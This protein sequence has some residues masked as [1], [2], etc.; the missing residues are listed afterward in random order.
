MKK[1]LKGQAALVTG[2]SKGIGFA[3]A[4]ALV[5][6]GVNVSITA[7]K[8]QELDEA[9]RR[10][11]STGPGRVQTYAVD[12]RDHRGV[13]NAVSDT[14]AAFGGLDIVIN[15]AGVGRFVNVADMSLDQWSEVID[16]NL[17]GVFNVCHA[18]IPELRFCIRQFYYQKRSFHPEPA[19]CLTTI[20]VPAGIEDA[21]GEKVPGLPVLPHST[22]HLYS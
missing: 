6:A 16:T 17:T 20:P 3:V 12:V 13:H 1:E 11:E 19:V 9:K 2:A 22:R 4:E 10:L 14:V 15:N 5:G 7:R 21:P 8:P 18:A